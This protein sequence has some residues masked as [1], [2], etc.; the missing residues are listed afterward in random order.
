MRC[1][2][3]CIHRRS[4]RS[5]TIS[6]ATRSA[7]RAQHRRRSSPSR[8]RVPPP[9][10]SPP[11]RTG[12]EP[13]PI[14]A[15][16]LRP[17]HLRHSAAH[18]DAPRHRRG[19][20]ADRSTIV[21]IAA[22]AGRGAPFGLTLIESQSLGTTGSIALRFRI[23]NG[24]TVQEIIRAAG[25]RADHRGR[26]A[27]LRLRAGAAAARRSHAGL[28]RRSRPAGDVD[29]YILEKLKLADVH[30][31]VSG[32]NVHDRGDRFRDRRRASR[33]RRA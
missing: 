24:Q 31:I 33:P 14:A 5:S 22:A 18:R 30:R 16:G 27:D 19:A 12:A 13:T 3:T 20:A 23:T 8:R 4:R 17:A 25:E 15:A 9:P 11:A 32:T 28:A 21:T 7:R 1:R 2:R 29:Q 26:A 6:S 10:G